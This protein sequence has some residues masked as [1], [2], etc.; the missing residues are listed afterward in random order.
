[1]GDRRENDEGMTP[2]PGI[3]AAPAERGNAARW[4]GITPPPLP[5][6]LKE[7]PPADATRPPRRC[8]LLACRG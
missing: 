8:C 7:K 1:M 6:C 5:H 4:D 3:I 2:A